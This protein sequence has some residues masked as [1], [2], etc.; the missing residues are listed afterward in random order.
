VQQ[1]QFAGRWVPLNG[2]V[3]VENAQWKNGSS[4]AMQSATLECVQYASTGATIYK[5]TTVLNGPTAAGATSTFGP[6]QMGALQQGMAK[7]QCGIVG[8]TPAG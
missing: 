3:E 4:E 8:V 2:N 6:F 5:I 1:Q 7:V